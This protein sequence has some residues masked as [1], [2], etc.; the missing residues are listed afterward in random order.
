MTGFAIPAGFSFT[1]SC[2]LS[3]PKEDGGDKGG[4]NAIDHPT[5]A[6]EAAAYQ[7]NQTDLEFQRAQPCAVSRPDAWLR[8][9]SDGDGTTAEQ[10][11]MD[12]AVDSWLDIVA[13]RN[14]RRVSDGT[15]N[16]L[17]IGEA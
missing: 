11:F 5:Q 7:H 2:A 17:Q 12:Y 1:P 4:A 6:G 8:P 16:T 3:L 15:S 13:A 14:C 9:N 10:G